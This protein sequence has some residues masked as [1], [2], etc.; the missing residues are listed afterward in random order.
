MEYPGFQSRVDDFDSLNL[1]SHC[2]YC[3]AHPLR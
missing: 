2:P 1:K 3:G